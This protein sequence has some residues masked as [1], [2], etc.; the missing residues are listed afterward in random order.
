MHCLLITLLFSATQV[1]A[2]LGL[3]FEKEGFLPTILGLVEHI[4]E[5]KTAVLL[6]PLLL[7]YLTKMSL[8]SY[9]LP[10]VHFHKTEVTGMNE[11]WSENCITGCT[12]VLG[13]LQFSLDFE[14]N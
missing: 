1:K 14:G 5:T 13:M 2:L 10:K 6:F 11:Y 7:F 9:P 4:H 8:L 12:I 3:H